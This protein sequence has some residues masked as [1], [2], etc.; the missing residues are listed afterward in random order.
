MR[1]MLWSLGLL[2]LSPG[3]AWAQLGQTWNPGAAGAGA[4]VQHA[5]PWS[6]ASSTNAQGVRI[7]EYVNDQGTVFAVSW[8]G[9]V[10]PDLRALLGPYFEPLRGGTGAVAMSHGHDLVVYSS[11]SMPHF[12]GYA[13]LKSQT[14]GGFQFPH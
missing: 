9:P 10:K 3:C 6:T 8:D 11:G 14:P 12:S 7:T 13:Y 5:Q 2:A 4:L 1:R